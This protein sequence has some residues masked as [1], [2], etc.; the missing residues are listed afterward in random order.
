MPLPRHNGRSGYEIVLKRKRRYEFLFGCGRETMAPSSLINLF[1]PL[2]KVMPHATA[3]RAF[4]YAP[5]YQG[6]CL[7]ASHELIVIQNSDQIFGRRF[8]RGAVLRFERDFDAV[9][10]RGETWIGSDGDLRVGVGH[11]A[12]SPGDVE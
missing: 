12:Q 10:G 2:P 9:V 1:V 4:C 11:G 8:E 5:S 7:L 6:H 3:Q